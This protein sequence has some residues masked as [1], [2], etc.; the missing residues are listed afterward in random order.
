VDVDLVAR[1]AL[2]ELSLSP[3]GSCGVAS[4]EADCVRGAF[5]PIGE[6][7]A[8][9][10]LHSVGPGTYPVYLRTNAAAPIALEVTH[11]VASPAPAHRDCSTPL[12]LESDLP[13]TADLALPGPPLESACPTQRGDLFYTFT[14]AQAADVQLTAESLDDLG[15]PRLALRGADCADPELEIG[16]ND[17]TAAALH[18]HALAAGTYVLAVSASGPTQARVALRVQPPSTPPPTDQ[19]STAPALV[20]NRTQTVS[21][22]D[23]IDDIVASCSPGFIDAAYALDVASP[24]DLL[25]VGRFSSGD[26]GSVGVTGA[27]C[28][29]ENIQDCSRPATNPARVSAQGLAAGSYRVVM[30]S[31]G[32]L[33]A[34]LTGALR[35]ARPRTFVPTSDACLEVLTIPPGGGIFQGNTQNADNDFSASCDFAT[36]NGAP[37]QLLKLVLDRPQRVLLDMRGSDFD[38]LLDVRRGPDCPGQEV[39]EACSVGVADDQSFLDLNLPAGEYFL[40][41]DGYAGALGAWLLDVF[42]M[43]P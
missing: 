10:H 34:T 33:P 8:R 11:L 41:I 24:S 16:C 4:E 43:D 40:Q 25:L 9:L 3:V 37:D 21:F 28:A 26:I 32:G 23:H 18:Y 35:P 5:L 22:I 29:D 13:V 20:V 15:R 38:T 14:L 31:A 2:G 27:D 30:E 6:S 36:P 19:C 1:S 39:P 12:L 42:V 7:V 17:G